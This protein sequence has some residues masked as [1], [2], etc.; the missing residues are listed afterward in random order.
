[1]RKFAIIAAMMAASSV[2]AQSS[3]T[4]VTREAPGGQNVNGQIKITATTL[5]ATNG[6]AISLGAFPVVYVNSVGANAET[7]VVTLAAASA[8]LVG[9]SFSII[10]VNSSNLLQ[11]TDSAPVYGTGAVL[12]Q[13]DT[14]S[15]FVKATNEII[16]TSTSNN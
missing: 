6:Q 3:Y 10:N 12:G 13:R 16:Q 9:A 15:F 5:T 2:F 1:M 11:I 4:P 14:V 8:D 7:N